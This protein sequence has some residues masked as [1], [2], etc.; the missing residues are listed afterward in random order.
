M[1]NKENKVGIH[2]LS[3][4]VGGPKTHIRPGF[5]VFRSRD[6]PMGTGSCASPVR[7]PLSSTAEGAPR[8]GAYSA[9]VCGS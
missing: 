5:V 3:L 4:G 8:L 6:I 2:F 9:D 7:A 1:N